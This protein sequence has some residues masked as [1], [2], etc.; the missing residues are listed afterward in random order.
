[1][2]GPELEN[3]T[4]TRYDGSRVTDSYLSRGRVPQADHKAS[5]TGMSLEL[6]DAPPDESKSSVKSADD[7]AL[8]IAPAAAGAGYDLAASEE[9]KTEAPPAS[10]PPDAARPECGR[11]WCDCLPSNAFAPGTC[12]G[13]GAIAWLVILVVVFGVTATAFDPIGARSAPAV[14]TTALTNTTADDDD[15]DTALS[16]LAQHFFVKKLF[17]A[18]SCYDRQEVVEFMEHFL[19]PLRVE[20][21]FLTICGVVLN[22]MLLMQ[23]EWVGESEGEGRMGGCY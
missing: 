21:I 18:L 7:V 4:A 2:A 8:A 3:G 17:K 15:C 23:G 9:S 6:T 19:D 5:E 13:G 22:Y 12:F 14:N 11:T 1:M 20:S 16:D 10:K